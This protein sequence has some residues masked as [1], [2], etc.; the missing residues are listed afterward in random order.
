MESVAGRRVIGL[1]LGAF[2]VAGCHS[3]PSYGG[4]GRPPTPEEIPEKVTIAAGSVQTGTLIGALRATVSVPSLSATTYPITVHRYKQCVGAGA[5]SPPADKRDM[6][7]PANDIRDLAGSRQERAR[8]P[9]AGPTYD[10]AGGDT[11]PVTCVAPSQA[12]DY[13]R[14]LSGSVPT[15]TQWQAAARGPAVTRYAW[16]NAAP[17]CERHPDACLGAVDIADYAVGR[18][19]ASASPTGVQD[20]L[21]TNSEL[22]RG[23]DGATGFACRGAGTHCQIGG[24]R[25]F[26]AIEALASVADDGPYPESGTLSAPYG[27]RCVFSEVK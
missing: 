24:A 18:R 17:T 16:G 9:L 1:I 5:C 14:W 26:A 10:M 3:A 20:V 22:V 23:E 21:L 12:E 19:P 7:D 11:L 15:S 4:P 6:C 27:F 25:D 13:C 8:G 2:A